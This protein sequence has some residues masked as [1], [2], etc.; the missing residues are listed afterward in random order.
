MGALGQGGAPYASVYL[1]GK[2]LKPVIG[3][4]GAMSYSAG[5]AP[6]P[7]VIESRAS[8]HHEHV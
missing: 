4:L 5:S 7:A 2:E 6:S 8:H 1:L 3:E